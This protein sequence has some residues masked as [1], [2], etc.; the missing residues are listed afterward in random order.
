MN[1]DRIQTNWSQYKANVRESFTKLTDADLDAAAG[2]RDQVLGKL[3]ERYGYSRDIAEQKLT[4][5]TT[6]V[7]AMGAKAG[8][9]QAAKTGGAQP[10]T[11]ATN[12]DRPAGGRKPEKV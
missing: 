6:K 3:Q 1:W 5:F 2:R 10:A 8:G 4:E 12:R 7:S 9:A 11:A